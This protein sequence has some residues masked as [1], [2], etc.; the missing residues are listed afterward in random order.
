MKDIEKH[1]LDP[2]ISP[3]TELLMLGTF[4]PKK[5]RWKMDFY[6]PNFQNDMWRIYG[7]CFFNDKDY[8]LNKERTRFEP[9]RIEQFLLYKGIGI[10]DTVESAIRLKDNASDK[11]LQVVEPT[12]L[13]ELLNKIPQ[14]K[15]IVTTGQKATEILFQELNIEHQEPKIGTYYEFQFE[16]RSM[17]L[18][19]MPS[20]SRAYPKSLTDKATIYQTMFEELNLIE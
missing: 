12:D 5:E 3:N 20:S 14:C 11:F 15:A 8:F 16:N 19:R 10:A 9:Q 4:P 17:R 6:Y 13:I 18:Y 1:P 2:F 7:L